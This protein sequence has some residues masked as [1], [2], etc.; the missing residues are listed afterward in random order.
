MSKEQSKEQELQKLQVKKEEVR[1]KYN[2]FVLGLMVT[3]KLSPVPVH[4]I[5]TTKGMIYE[6]GE[7]EFMPV[8][9]NEVEQAKKQIGKLNKEES[10]KIV[11]AT[12]IKAK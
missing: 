7:I 6:I 2:R 4:P 12:D 10:K 5:L 1:E 3:D 11:Y 8:N 9:D